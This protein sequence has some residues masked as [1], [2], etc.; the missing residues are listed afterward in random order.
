MKKLLSTL[1]LAAACVAV[2]A[3]AA[4][5][6]APVPNPTNF[7]RKTPPHPMANPTASPDTSNLDVPT[8]LRQKQ[9]N[10]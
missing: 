2:P 10:G 9:G 7:Y 5:A 3:Q 8:F 4:V 1:A 6:S